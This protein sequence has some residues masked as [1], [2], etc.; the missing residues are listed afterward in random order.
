ML[1]NVRTVVIRVL[2]LF[3]G[4]K[5]L[6]CISSDGKVN[7]RRG[8][9]CGKG[10]LLGALGGELCASNSVE[11]GLGSSGLDDGGLVGMVIDLAGDSDS[12]E[13]DILVGC[14]KLQVG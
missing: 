5:L 9:F 13:E 2:A 3:R 14:G 12:D 4:G 6:V 8:R 1:N 7:W 10:A 11:G